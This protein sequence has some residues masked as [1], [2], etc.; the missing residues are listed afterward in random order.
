MVF[1]DV[2][3]DDLLIVVPRSEIIKCKLK[4][5]K[6]FTSTDQGCD[7]NILSTKADYCLNGKLP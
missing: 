5:T 7:S 1:F 4:L 3:V 6:I 2:N